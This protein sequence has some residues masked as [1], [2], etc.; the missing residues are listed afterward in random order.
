MRIK[1]YFATENTENAEKKSLIAISV[2]LDDPSS[3]PGKKAP[4]SSYLL[5]RLS[6]PTQAC[7]ADRYRIAP[8]Y[9]VF[10]N[11]MIRYRPI[12]PRGG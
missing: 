2:P 12:K 10:L 4:K 7:F 9:R 1:A 8:K 6:D 5:P 11:W 3:L